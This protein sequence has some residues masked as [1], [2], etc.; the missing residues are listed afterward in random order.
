MNDIF[1]ITALHYLN[2]GFE[3][4]NHFQFILNAIIEN[5]ANAE[6]PEINTVHA[7][8]LYKGHKKDKTVD[9]SY[10]TISTCPFIAKCL[11]TYSAGGRNLFTPNL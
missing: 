3:A 7:H 5:I 1:S 10:R 2:G 9:S 4:L 6:I 11:D 8:I